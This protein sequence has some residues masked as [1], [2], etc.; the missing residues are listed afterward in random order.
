MGDKADNIPG[1]FKCGPKT[2][3]KWLDAY[4]DLKGVIANASEVKGKIGENLREAVPNLPLSYDL[5]TIKLDVELAE[6]LDNLG[7][8]SPDTEALRPMLERYQFRAWLNELDGKS[9]PAKAAAAP[10]APKVEKIEKRDY[11]II[12]TKVVLNRWIKTIEESG[13]FAFDTETTSLNY[14]DA[15]IVG[16]SFA[17]TPGEAAY[18]PLAHDYEGVPAQLDRDETLTKLKPL[19]E[20]DSV[21]K[22]GQNLKYDRNVL[23]NHGIDLRGITE[24][25]MLQSYVCLLYTSDAADE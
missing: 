21:K 14:M 5:A 9:A 17:V 12:S 8:K 11:Q 2:A 18:L 24:D 22:I 19:L 6:T 13:S 10:K 3:V 7:I 20:N 4:D 16:L 1:V 15:E 23:L 25:T